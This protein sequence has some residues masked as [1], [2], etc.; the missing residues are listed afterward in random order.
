MG[1]WTEQVERRAAIVLDQMAAARALAV[2][3]GEDPFDLTERYREMLRGLYDN[4]MSIARLLDRADLV[5]WFEGKAVSA[6]APSMGIVGYAC[7]ELR[8]QIKKI[9][10]AIIGLTAD[11]DPVWSPSLEL[12][13]SGMAHGS[14]VVGVQLQ[15][16]SDVAPGETL[17]LLD[18]TDPVYQAVRRAV[19]GLAMIA[20][21]FDDDG[22]AD[23]IREAF[24]DPAERDT[25][26]VA[27]HQ[28]SPSGRRGIDRILLRS[29]DTAGYPPKTLTPHSRKMLARALVKPLR[30]TVATTL[31]GVARAIDLDARRFE[32]R[33]INGHQAVRC[34]YAPE[35]DAQ[36]HRWLNQRLQVAGRGERAPNGHPRLLLAESVSVLK[37]TSLIQK[38]QDQDQAPDLKRRAG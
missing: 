33:G 11:S 21:Y 30:E 32:L 6:T 9:S 10:K 34:L 28:L 31:C 37:P 12:G 29:P 25:L 16:L 27:A 17:T 23:S 7:Q 24:P 19:R 13:L 20:R 22:L 3:F 2:K 5:A 8:Q 38:S 18:D 35:L 36:A 14:L 1:G 15:A 26:L 4:D